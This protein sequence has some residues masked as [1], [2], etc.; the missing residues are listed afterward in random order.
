MQR[1]FFG[2]LFK[3]LLLLVPVVVTLY[4]IWIIFTRIDGLLRLPVPG[5]GFLV[6]ILFIWVVG[7]LGSTIFFGNIFNWM[8]KGL[9]RLPVVKLLYSSIKDLI[10]AFV[11]EKKSFNR[12]VMISLGLPAPG[13][14]L[15]EGI[16]GQDMR[17]MGFITSDALAEF[18]DSQGHVAVYVPTSYNFGGF[19]IL[20]PK[21][22]ITPLDT[23][24]S[25]KLMAFIV[26]GG[27]AK[28]G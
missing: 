23:V 6:T 24:D 5:L 1:F 15:A 2:N 21:N 10:G 13:G 18:P 14:A 17:L 4:V 3:G 7:F 25:A 19:L 28:G 12:P 22:R 8:E 26:S 11:G 27:V 16:P 9:T 20:V